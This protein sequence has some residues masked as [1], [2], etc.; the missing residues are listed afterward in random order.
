[1]N[2]FEKWGRLKDL[3]PVDLPKSHEAAPV[4]EAREN[5]QLNP[6]STCHENAWWESVY[7]ALRCGCCHPPASF[8]AVRRWLGDPE[9]YAKMKARTPAVVLYL[10]EPR[11]RKAARS[12]D[13]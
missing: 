9:A 4:Q 13:T 8:A 2:F 11:Q 10:G 7:G 12:R 1:M 5:I 6:C 3:G